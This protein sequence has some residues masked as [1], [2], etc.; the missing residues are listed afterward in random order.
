GRA[1]ARPAVLEEVALRQGD[2]VVHALLD[3]GDDAAEV[4]ALDVAA[5][6]QTAAS[7]LAAPLV[8]PRSEADV[9]QVPER[10][11]PVV[12]GQLQPQSL[13]IVVIDAE[14]LAPA[15]HPVQA[16]PPRPSPRT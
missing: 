13:Q 11:L 6:R 9:G 16:P 12:S 2:L 4:A 10:D 1:P 15:H 8:G 5:D 7:V 3:V 14:R